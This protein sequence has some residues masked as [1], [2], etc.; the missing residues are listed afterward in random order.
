MSKIESHVE[1]EELE[2]LLQAWARNAQKEVRAARAIRN[3]WWID[4]QSCLRSIAQA[5]EDSGW[6][7]SMATDNAES[8]WDLRLKQGQR[9]LLFRVVCALQPLEEADVARTLRGA[10]A[11]ADQDLSGTADPDDCVRL[12]LTFVAPFACAEAT[13]NQVDAL[14]SRWLEHK[15]FHSADPMPWA[16]AYVSL[17]GARPQRN[18]AGTAFPC[19]ALMMRRAGA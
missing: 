5:A 12:A 3:P 2:P 18:Q 16:F 19:L 4:H 17:A 9:T 14:L 1:L 11:V 8:A 6:I 7:V 15:P 10:Q 13:D